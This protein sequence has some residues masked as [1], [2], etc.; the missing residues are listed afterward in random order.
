MG[1][2]LGEGWPFTGR[3][4]S[5]GMAALLLSVVAPPQAGTVDLVQST[6]R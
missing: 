6:L 5:G 2:G 3:T 4:G 1:E